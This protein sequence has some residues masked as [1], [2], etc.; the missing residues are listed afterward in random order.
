MTGGSGV[1]GP[2]KLRRR[3]ALTAGLVCLALV[4]YFSVVIIRSVQP[5]AAVLWIMAAA[6]TGVLF[7]SVPPF[8][9]VSAGSSELAAAVFSAFLLP[10][11]AF[12]LQTSQVH[13][14]LAMTGFPISALL[15]AMFLA[16]ELP[17]YSADLKTEK[18]TLLVRIG[19]QA[20]INLH[21]ILILS[22]YLILLAA[23]LFG[24]PRFAVIAGMLS[25]PIGLFQ[26]WRM[27]L[28]VDGGKPHWASLTW[29]G[30]MLVG[31]TVYLLAYSFWIH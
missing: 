14:L 3:T 9:L 8:R 28:I 18:H 19:W 25:M 29:T 4:A 20:G 15:L 12:I 7:C 1:I 17:D 21:N 31:L 30:L 22:A 27:R 10:A 6:I 24:Y 16:F 26:I 2:G 11:F 5:G 13:R 23:G